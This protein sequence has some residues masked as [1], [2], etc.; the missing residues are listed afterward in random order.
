MSAKEQKYFNAV[1]PFRLLNIHCMH[2]HCYFECS[3]SKSLLFNLFSR[4]Y[5]QVYVYNYFSVELVDSISSLASCYL[6]KV[7]KQFKPSISE[8]IAAQWALLLSMTTGVFL[9]WEMETS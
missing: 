8:H 5:I 9:A 3:T 4:A 2:L 7:L 6:G 1:S